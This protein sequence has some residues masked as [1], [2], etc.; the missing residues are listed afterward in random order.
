MRSTPVLPLPRQ[1]AQPIATG[2]PIQRALDATHLQHL[3][4]ALRKDLT[5]R[6]TAFNQHLETKPKKRSGSSHRNQQ[7]RMLHEI[8]QRANVYLRDNPR[9]ATTPQRQ[10]LF[11]LLRQTEDHHVSATQKAMQAQDPLW[12]H[13]GVQG[14][15]A[16]HA[17]NLWRSIVA[18]K[19]NLHIEGNGDFRAQ[20]HSSIA[21]LLQGKHGRSLLRDLN[22]KQADQERRITIRRGDESAAAPVTEG[23][24]IQGGDQ[25]NVGTGSIVTIADRG[26]APASMDAYESGM[27]GEAISAPRFVTLGHEL[28]HARHN[29]AGTAGNVAWFGG[30]AVQ[31]PVAQAL[32]TNPEEYSNI[33]GEE[34]PIRAEHG[35]PQRQYHATIGSGRST[36]HRVEL[37]GRLDRLMATVPNEHRGAL[38]PSLGAI[39]GRLTNT[40]LSVDQN[41][42]TLRAEVEEAER[43]MP[44]RIR[45]EQ[46]KALGNG[47][48]G[49]ASSGFDWAKRKVGLA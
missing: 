39:N 32:W 34:N 30:E 13:S 38:G 26:D 16:K 19:G 37:G 43:A 12:L 44:N 21:R 7:F 27:Q 49:L 5:S 23:R 9:A 28:G 14:T 24:N 22:Q 11:A 48:L 15:D 45:W 47:A 4:E 6:V 2:A 3:P 10:G 35:M 42:Q 25:P 31:D 40:D 8:E 18:G 46:A 41:A 20:T 33:Q 29:L 36:R 1:A 17:R